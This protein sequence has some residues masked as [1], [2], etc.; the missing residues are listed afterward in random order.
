VDEDSR[1]YV[2]EQSPSFAS[3]V[4]PAEPSSFNPVRTITS[5]SWNGGAPKPLLI[6]P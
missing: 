2:A 6:G 4:L 1:V 5:G 3:Q